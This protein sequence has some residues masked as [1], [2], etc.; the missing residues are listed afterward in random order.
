MR[1]PNWHIAVVV[2]ALLSLGTLLAGSG[3]AFS[4]GSSKTV[5]GLIGLLHAAERNYPGLD[6]AKHKIDAA[7]AKL[8][9]AWVSPLLQ[10]QVVG[11]AG[12]APEAQGTPLFSPNSELPLS[13]SWV[14]YARVGVEGAVP[15]WTFGKIGAARDAARAGVKA[16][17]HEESQTRARLYYDVKRA[18]FALQMA[19]DSLQMVSEGKGR[20]KAASD[21]LAKRIEAGDPDTDEMDRYRLSSTVAE[22]QARTADAHQLEESSRQALRTLTGLQEIH[23]LNCPSTAIDFDPKPLEWYHHAARIHRPEIHM[24]RAGLDAR[25]AQ[26]DLAVANYFP[27]LALAL[28]ATYGYAPGIDDQNNPFVL[29][30]ANTRVLTAGLIARWSL[31]FWGN[32]YREQNADSELLST[33]YKRDEALRG[34]ILEV[35]T[36]YHE[37]QSAIS[38]ED[39]WGKGHKDTRAWFLAA[40][41]AYQVGTLE[42]DD[43]VDAIRAYFTAR[44]NHIESIRSFNSSAANLERVVGTPLIPLNRWERPCE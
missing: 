36:V 35:S 37:M 11:A 7:E 40:A 10:F 25:K 31:D 16:S 41:Q 39:A 12:M 42:A 33:Q 26:A 44:I 22:I 24:L 3:A 9:E 34:V 28:S 38:R 21:S 19:L 18:Y 6:A 15:L 17:K 29:D 2:V 32:S 30:R 27:D 20:L 5:R 14:P 4:K 13:N 1:Q 23:E 43:L 8:G